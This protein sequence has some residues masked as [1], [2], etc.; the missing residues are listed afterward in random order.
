MKEFSN[1]IIITVDDDV[2][3]EK[4]LIEKLIKSYKKF[5]NSI[6]CI[7]AHRITFDENNR[8]QK[9]SM[10][11]KKVKIYAKERYDLIAIGIGGVLYP[12][13]IL[14]EEVFNTKVLREKCLFTDDIWLKIIELLSNVK[15]VKASKNSGWVPII[16][17]TQKEALFHN[18]M[19]NNT[20]NDDSINELIK[21]YKIDFNKYKD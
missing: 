17:N 6:S 8:I 12:P 15:V 10:W 13:N 14:L 3:Y 7:R 11:E 18:N 2:C 9:Y 20:R 4:K 5:P 21:K 1:D 16:S 19:E